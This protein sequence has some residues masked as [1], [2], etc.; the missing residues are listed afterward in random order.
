MTNKINIIRQNIRNIGSPNDVQFNR[1]AIFRPNVIIEKAQKKL[2]SGK[3]S[4]G[5]S[6][7]II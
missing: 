2:I 4:R 1:L 7:K 5:Q 6:G 3:S